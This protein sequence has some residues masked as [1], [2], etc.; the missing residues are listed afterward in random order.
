MNLNYSLLMPSRIV[1]GWGVRRELP[2]I[3][4]GLGDRVLLLTG[5][6]TLAAAGTI[7]ALRGECERAGVGVTV[8]P[9]P[10][11]EPLVADVDA[12]VAQLAPQQTSGTVI[13]GVGGGST[14]DLAK[15]V[16]A[17]LPNSSGES[18]REYLEGVGTGRTLTRT[19]LPMIAVPTTAGTGTEA[20]KN[21]VISN[22]DP[23][24]KKSLRAD[25]MLP[26]CALIDPELTVSLPRSITAHTGLDAITQLIESYVSRRAAPIPQGLAEQGL[27][28]ALAALPRVMA[29]PADR[30]AREALA[31]A[32]LLSGIALANAGLG[33]A[34]GVAAGLGVLAQ[35][36]HGLACALLL[37]TAVRLNTSVKAVELSRLAELALGRSFSTA[38]A[39][40]TALAEKLQTLCDDCGIPRRIRDVGLTID[41]LPALVQA[42]HGNS[43]SG[44]PR[45]ITD[46]ELYDVLAAIW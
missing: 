16:A 37:P 25:T 27:P 1:F 30:P 15:A 8:V 35:V 24:F 14:L 21:A 22:L 18:V 31:H 38:E 41:Q 45:E 23:P 4:R 20:T 11:H 26:R 39:G 5:S 33:V 12:L 46:S 19:P 40:A 28:A 34:H 36:P 10:A 13:V 42:S 6:R 9:V 2:A 29:D 43:L 32:A 17:L 3:A 44:N 7:E